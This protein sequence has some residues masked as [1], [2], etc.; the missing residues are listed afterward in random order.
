LAQESIG[1]S[2]FLPIGPP[3]EEPAHARILLLMATIFSTTFDIAEWTQGGG[4]DPAPTGDDINR[5][6]DWTTDQGGVAQI[7]AAANHAS[8]AGGRGMRHK[9]GNAND[10]DNDTSGGLA[11]LGDTSPLSG[12]TH[13]W[14]RYYCRW[15][16]G[17][18]WG[19]GGSPS[20]TKDLDIQSSGSRTIFGHQNGAWGLWQETGTTYPLTS[21]WTW[22]DM[23]GGGTSDGNW[24]LMEFELGQNTGGANTG[25]ARIWIDDTLRGE[26]T[27]C[28]INVQTWS[29]IHTMVNANSVRN[30]SGLTVNGGGAAKDWTI[31]IDDFAISDSARIGPI[32]AAAAAA[33][34]GSSLGGMG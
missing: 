8:G 3:V 16:S 15:E 30:A 11:L 2:V 26:D 17:M 6:G 21:S 20:Y 4:L 32:G 9:W 7:V 23:M 27:T 25:V 31:D 13:I 19:G 22:V 34:K 24:H 10:G 28:D 18:Q 14:V 29:V 5:F 12:K 1:G 33:R